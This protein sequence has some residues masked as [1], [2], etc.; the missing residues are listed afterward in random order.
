M[1]VYFVKPIGDSTMIKVGHTANLDARMAA[2]AGEFE[3]GVEVLALCDGGPETERAIHAALSDTRIEGEWFAP[4]D[5]MDAL[6]SSYAGSVKGRR[7]WGRPSAA[8]DDRADAINEDWALARREL[9]KLMSRSGSPKTGISIRYAFRVLSEM[10]PLWT[11]RRVR[12]IWECK[13]RRIDL[14]EYRNLLMANADNADLAEWVA[15]EIKE[16]DDDQ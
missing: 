14:F 15:P 7:V 9:A 1:S 12:A 3:G 2:I 5:T 16:T 6:I 8:R 11:S 4:S 13:A 10:N